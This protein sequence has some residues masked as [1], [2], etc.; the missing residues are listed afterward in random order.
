MAVAERYR[1]LDRFQQRHAWLAFPLAVY[2]KF[3]DDQAGY[4]AVVI[5]YYGFFSVFPL[6]L[7]FT[8]V[9]GYVLQDHPRLYAQIVDS[10]LAQFPVIGPDLQVQA[11]TGNPAAVVIGLVT[12]VWAGMGVF[13]ASQNAMNQI[14]GVP[15]RRR[16]GFLPARLRAL[17]LLVALGGGMLAATAASTFARRLAS[18]ALVFTGATFA[19]STLLGFGLYWVGFRVLA[20][21]VSWRQ[22]RGGA[23]AAAVLFSILQILGSYYI[24]RVVRGATNTYGTFAL[25][26]GLLSWIYLIAVSTLLAAEA[27]AVATM[28]LWPRSL[29]WIGELPPTGADRTAMR[30]RARI[31]QRRRDMNVR[32]DVPGDDAGEAPPGRRDP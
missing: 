32:L 8:S 10:A 19:F 1:A 25:V 17:A 3:S 9:L 13:L 20:T 15:F 27:N 30:L 24:D 2:Q 11:L 31:E 28:G 29:T 4:L 5:T 7:V 12:A 18:H 21:G 6:L 16:P 23:F 14:W 26:I 22:V